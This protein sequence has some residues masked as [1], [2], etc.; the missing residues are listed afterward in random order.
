MD[1]AISMAGNVGTEV[2]YTSG[3]GYSFASFRLAATPRIRR[4]GEWTD[5]ETVWTTVQAVNRTAENVRASVHKGEAVV[6]VGRLRARRWVGQDGQQHERLVLEA[7]S[8]G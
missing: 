5:G 1:T 4:G 7:K 6:V 8:V 2:D 3:E